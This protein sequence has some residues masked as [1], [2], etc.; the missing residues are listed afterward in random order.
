MEI[1]EYYFRIEEDN[2]NEKV[3]VLIIYDIVD[4]AKRV[5]LAKTLGAYGFRVQ[6]SAFEAIITRKKYDKML[7]ELK[8]YVNAEDSIRIYKI[9]G[10]GQL[11][12]LGK[13]NDNT[14][15]DIIVI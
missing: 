7:T 8:A 2:K 9:V 5:R 10:K 1:E 13:Q 3:F 6:K 11:Q 4:N 12:V 15:D 14:M